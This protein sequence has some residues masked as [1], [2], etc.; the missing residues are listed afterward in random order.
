MRGSHGAA[1]TRAGV[2]KDWKEEK[3]FL[4][5]DLGF[6]FLLSEIDE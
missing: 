6:P 5:R 2:R 4:R 3:A 1:G